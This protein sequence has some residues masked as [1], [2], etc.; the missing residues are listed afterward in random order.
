MTAVPQVP[1]ATNGPTLA[2]ERPVAELLSVTKHFELGR[3]TSR[4]RRKVHAV[5]D[6]DLQIP[7][8]K[9]VGL[10]GETGS[11]KSTVARLLLRLIEPTSGTVRVDEDDITKARGTTLRAL[12]RK[13]QLVF[14]D[15][16]SSFDP[17][18]T[19]AASIGEALR[20][21]TD[22]DAGGR[23]ERTGELLEQTG[24][25]ARLMDRRPRELSGG[26]LQRAAVARALAVSPALI[27][28][29]E[30]VSSLDVS[31]QAQVINLLA[32]LQRELGVAYLFISH[33]LSVVRH[34][35]HRIAVMYLGKLMEVGPTDTIGQSP[36]HPYTQALLSAVPVPDPARQRGR[37]RIVLRGDIPSPVDPP[38][39]CRFRTRCPEAMSVCATLEPSA[40]A[41]P[42]GSVVYCHLFPPGSAGAAGQQ[43]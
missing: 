38:S 5:D 32:D 27:A 10:V 21:H 37:K 35:S 40:S 23:R 18:T 41:S 3:G 42:D 22:L 1:S 13:M 19:I 25:S 26:Q 14:Q 34:V 43:N 12:R 15:P 29:D 9:T 39:G 20:V 11:G 17:M 7:A 2:D 24:L 33:D 4:S 30:P 28:L 16:Y 6:F 31:T 8:G 36:R